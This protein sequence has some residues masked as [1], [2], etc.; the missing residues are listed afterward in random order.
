MIGQDHGHLYICGEI[1]MASQVI[2]ALESILR[3]M[4]IQ[5]PKEF[6]SKLKED[7]RLH[8]DIFGNN[9]QHN[10]ISNQNPGA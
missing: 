10:S 4:N 5:D 1:T 6:I 8:E 9:D 3:S 2:E 7:H